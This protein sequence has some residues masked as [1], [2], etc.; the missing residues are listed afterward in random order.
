MELEVN[1][2]AQARESTVYGSEI[3]E[4]GAAAADNMI[5]PG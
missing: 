1:E 2:E 5:V 4:Y 3:D